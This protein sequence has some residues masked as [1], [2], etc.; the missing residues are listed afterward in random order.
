[1]DIFWSVCSYSLQLRDFCKIILLLKINFHGLSKCEKW[2][3]NVNINFSM[4]LIFAISKQ[5]TVLGVHRCR[6]WILFRYYGAVSVVVVLYQIYTCVSYWTKNVKC[7]NTFF[8]FLLK[9]VLVHRASL[10]LLGFACCLLQVKFWFKVQWNHSY[11]TSLKIIEW[12]IGWLLVLPC[13]CAC[14]HVCLR[15]W[16]CVCVSPNWIFPTMRGSMV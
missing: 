15:V 3:H 7:Q 13:V 8:F 2:M 12:K 4:L 9:N 11:N 16:V 6:D 5:R 14:M 10:V 1:M